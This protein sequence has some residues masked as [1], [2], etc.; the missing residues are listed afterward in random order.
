MTEVLG[1]A[2]SIGVKRDAYRILRY[3]SYWILWGFVALV[4]VSSIAAAFQ[5]LQQ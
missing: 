2:N 5:G 1:E 3:T 4:A